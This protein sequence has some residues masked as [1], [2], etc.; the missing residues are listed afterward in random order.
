MTLMFKTAEIGLGERNLNC[1]DI[2]IYRPI[3]SDNSN[4]QKTYTAL[5]LPAWKHSKPI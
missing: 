4:I 3:T 5:T 2:E 1:F